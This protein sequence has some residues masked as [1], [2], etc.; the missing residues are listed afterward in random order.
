MAKEKQET[1]EKVQ[2]VKQR[3]N[4]SQIQVSDKET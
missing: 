4:Q 3:T 1:K 2:E